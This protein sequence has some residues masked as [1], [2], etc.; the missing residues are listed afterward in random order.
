LNTEDFVNRVDQ[1]HRLLV[2][3]TTSSRRPGIVASVEFVCAGAALYVTVMTN[4]RTCRAGVGHGSLHSL[5]SGTEQWYV[6]SSHWTGPVTVQ[7]TSC[8]ARRCNL[9]T[10][11]CRR[12]TPC[13]RYCT[14]S[15]TECVVYGLPRILLLLIFS[16]T[17]CNTWL[18]WSL[19]IA[20]KRIVSVTVI[21]WSY[22]NSSQVTA[23]GRRGNYVVDAVF[24]HT[25]SAIFL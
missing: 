13:R 17:F 19:L 18:I 1:A 16:T 22:F 11:W 8:A 25:G 4:S 12:C 5:A 10:V 24:S 15:G 21:H 23:N 6:P 7:C 2:Y 9:C 14:E 3:R 20:S